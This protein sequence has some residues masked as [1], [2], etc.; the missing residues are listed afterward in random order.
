MAEEREQCITCKYWVPLS[1]TSTN[2][3]ECH[4]RSPIPMPNAMWAV[5]KATSLLAWWYMR[6]KSDEATAD[7]QLK[8][9]SCTLEDDEPFELI[10]LLQI[11]GTGVVTTSS[12]KQ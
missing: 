1:R 4:R 9:Y 12:E 5:A 7:E 3:G 8:S 6:E 11:L 2:R 10:G